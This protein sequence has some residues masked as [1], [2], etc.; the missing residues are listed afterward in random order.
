MAASIMSLPMRG[1]H[2]EILM[3]PD[4]LLCQCVGQ[5]VSRP[6][7]LRFIVVYTYLC[8][9]SELAIKWCYNNYYKDIHCFCVTERKLKQ[10]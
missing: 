8:F 5:S 3:F 7:S 1:L 4:S 2:G 6:G 9:T 10:D